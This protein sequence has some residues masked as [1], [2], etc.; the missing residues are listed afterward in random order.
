[1]TRSTGLPSQSG[2]EGEGIRPDGSLH[3]QPGAEPRNTRPRPDGIIGLDTNNTERW[4][5]GNT[6]YE[7]RPGATT[8]AGEPERRFISRRAALPVIGLGIAGIAYGL[9]RWASSEGQ[10]SGSSQQSARPSPTPSQVETTPSA[11][12]EPYPGRTET[13]SRPSEV[14]QD[15]VARLNWALNHPSDPIDPQDPNSRTGADILR[16]GVFWPLGGPGSGDYRAPQPSYENLDWVFQ[17]VVVGLRTQ[18]ANSAK[19]PGTRLRVVFEQSDHV[20]M[21]D[22]RE[23]TTSPTAFASSVNSFAIHAGIRVDYITPANQTGLFMGLEGANSGS[24]MD[25]T[26]IFWRSANGWVLGT[27][28]VRENGDTSYEPG[29]IESQL[30]TTNMF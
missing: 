16:D 5:V 2:S 1:M 25:G 17:N 9:W 4:P 14:V 15:W 18:I 20:L 8:Q 10:T 21:M 29:Y 27:Y 3:E 7:T 23:A 30:H 12:I 22:E 6:R 13:L 19:P 26:F 24:F 28:L 11:Q